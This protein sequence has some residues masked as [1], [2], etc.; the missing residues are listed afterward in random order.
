MLRYQNFSTNLLYCKL[1]N[2]EVGIFNTTMLV[3]ENY[4]R[5]LASPSIFYA[6]P[7]E[8]LYNY[9]SYAGNITKLFKNYKNLY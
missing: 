7:D 2:S 1:D 5:S 4:G 8:K 6:T 3:S 9:Q